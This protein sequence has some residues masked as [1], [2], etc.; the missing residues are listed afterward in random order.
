M[1]NGKSVIPYELIKNQNDLNISPTYDND[2]FNINDFYSSLKNKII[3]QEDYESVKKFY[4]KL[5]LKNKSDLNDIYNFQDTIILCEIF[6]SHVQTMLKKYGFNPRKCLSSST[7]S[8]CI[9]GKMSKVII[10][11]PTNTENIEVLEKTLI[12]G[13]SYVNT[14]LA[15][16]SNILWPKNKEDGTRKTNLKVLYNIR[17]EKNK[18]LRR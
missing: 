6:E 7:L 14:H 10:S 4:K 16:D 5:R 12:G 15:F 11:L 17:N 2:F 9:H 8:G 18:F 3:S 13:F 1:S